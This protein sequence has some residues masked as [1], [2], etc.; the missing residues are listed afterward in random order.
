M[1]CQDQDTCMSLLGWPS[2]VQSPPLGPQLAAH[3]HQVCTGIEDPV[4]GRRWGEKREGSAVWPR[5]HRGRQGAGLTSGL[6]MDLGP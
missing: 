4:D 6:C 2:Q 5:S 1:A 3:L